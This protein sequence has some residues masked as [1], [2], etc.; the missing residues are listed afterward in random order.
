MEFR[1][2]RSNGEWRWVL[3]TGSPW[4]RDD[5]G[6]FSGYIGTCIDVTDRRQAE[7][8][9]R[10]REQRLRAILTAAA[11]AI[12]TIDRHGALVSV[13]PAAERIFGYRQEEILGRNVTVLMANDSDFRL[14]LPRGDRSAETRHEVMARRKDGTPFPVEVTVSEVEHRHLFMGIIRDIS[15]R[16]QTEEALDHYRRDLQT[17]SA[18]LML[19]EERERQQL[20]QDLHDGLG[21]AIFLARRKLDQKSIAEV[22]SILD[23]VAGMVDNL[24][25]ELSPRVLQQLGFRSAIRWLARDM[26]RRYGLSIRMSIEPGPPFPFEEGVSVVLYRSVRELLINVARHAKTDFATLK[27]RK[28]RSNVVIV[29]EDRGKGFDVEGQVRPSMARRFGLFSIRERLEYLGGTFEIKS[30]PGKGTKITLT[31]PLLSAKAAAKGE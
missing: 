8:G 31:A 9:I 12:I 24:T 23:E 10:E 5:S 17:M 3:G 4:Y 20:A 22:G 18:E 30:T 25:S 2:R 21:Q 15:V 11:D 29:V 1:F 19:A 26:H 16:K 7:D 6:T 28:H 27:V 14:Y 13:N